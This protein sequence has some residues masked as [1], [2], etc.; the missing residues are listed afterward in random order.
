MLSYWNL[1]VASR[2]QWA[3]AIHARAHSG[4]CIHLTKN[5]EIVW[6]QLYRHDWLMACVLLMTHYRLT[7]AEEGCARILNL[8]SSR[9]TLVMLCRALGTDE[10]GKLLFTT[11]S[12]STSYF[13]DYSNFLRLTIEWLRATIALVPFRVKFSSTS[14]STQTSQ[15]DLCNV[16]RCSCVVFP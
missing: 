12:N 3:Y 5:L 1:Q 11:D 6:L 2:V 9:H 15:A 10:T 13:I 8:R 7:I 16:K 14:E 4:S